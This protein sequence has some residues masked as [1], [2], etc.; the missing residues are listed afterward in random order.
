[1]II[2]I[3]DDKFIRLS[4]SLKAKQLKLNFISFET[5]EN[6]LSASHNI[7]SEDINIYV[8]SNL[9]NGIKG[10][11]ESKKIFDLGFHNIFLTTGYEDLNLSPYPWITKIVSKSFPQKIS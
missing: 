8:D 2:L 1:M 6:F 10:E 11:Q 3:D 5:V 4:W 9:G 7:S